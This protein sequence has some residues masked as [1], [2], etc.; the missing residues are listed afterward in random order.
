MNRKEA[1]ALIEKYLAGHCTA[2]ERDLVERV[3]IQTINDADAG[4]SKEDVQRYKEQLRPALAHILQGNADTPTR[5]VSRRFRWLPYAAA[6]AILL[7][8]GW[9]LLDDSGQ[10]TVDSLAATEILPGGNRATLTLADGRVINLDEAQTGIIVGAEAITYDDGSAVSP[11]DS[12][13][14]G[15]TTYDLQ[16][17]TPKGGTYQITLPDGSKVWLNANST[18]KYPSR[19][20]GESRDVILEGEAFF[21]IQEIQGTR[22]TRAPF[23][24]LTAGQTVEV[25]GTEFNISA[26]KDDPETK[27]TL[28]EGKVRVEANGA[29]LQLV[30]GEQGTTAGEGL[31][32]H[33]VDTKPFTAWKDGY[34]ILKGTV[35]EILKQ[36]SRWYDV[37]VAYEDT[38]PAE[39]TVVLNMPRDVPLADV[40]YALQASEPAMQYRLELINKGS[41]QKQAE[42]RLTIF[43][44]AY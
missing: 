15:L 14:A 39:A 12:P 28:V 23:K 4:V 20:S 8:V 40:L 44:K 5:T 41:G 38:L 32:K 27:T 43:R 17:T 35:P 37:E 42:R 30:P 19:F 11:A 3:V 10:S 24:V 2:E 25:L 7:A 1:E 31:T 26:Y 22:D 29:S 33:R 21:E 6:A 36:I 13:N 18:L 34:F 9:L 16:L